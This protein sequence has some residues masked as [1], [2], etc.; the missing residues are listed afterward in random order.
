MLI[1]TKIQI[2]FDQHVLVMFCTVKHIF[3]VSLAIKCGNAN[4]WL[5]SS[6]ISFYIDDFPNKHR[7]YI[8]DHKCDILLCFTC[9]YPT[10]PC[11]MTTFNREHCDKHWQNITFGVPI[12]AYG[13][14][15]W[16]KS[17]LSQK[18]LKGRKSWETP[19]MMLNQNLHCILS[20]EPMDKSP[21]ETTM[22]ALKL[23]G[24]T[25]FCG[26]HQHPKAGFAGHPNTSNLSRV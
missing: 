9:E 16:H 19:N 26:D 4:V 20:L 2:H 5:V 18:W 1:G 25:P 22:V 3:S 12:S 23:L 17:N 6:C 13:I 7:T 8:N 14:P 11:W 24:M 21:L 15:S 10:Y